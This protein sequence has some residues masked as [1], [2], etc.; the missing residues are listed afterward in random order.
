MAGVRALG[1]LSRI[2]ARRY[3]VLTESSSRTFSV[4]SAMMARTHVNYEVKGDVAVI[5]MN[6]P[7]SKV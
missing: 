5:R 3:P 7:N 1:V 2:A 6:D 4:A